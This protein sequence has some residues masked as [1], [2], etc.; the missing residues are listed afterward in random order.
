MRKTITMNG[1]VRTKQ[2]RSRLPKITQISQMEFSVNLRYLWKNFL[3]K[4]EN[5]KMKILNQYILQFVFEKQ[6]S[7]GRNNEF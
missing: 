1:F 3:T 5:L 2:E 7:Y 6:Y 4:N